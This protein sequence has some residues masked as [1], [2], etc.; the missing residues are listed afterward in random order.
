VLDCNFVRD[1]DGKDVDWSPKRSYEGRVSAE[2]VDWLKADLA[3]TL[4]PTVIISHQGFGP[5]ASGGVVPNGA[6]IR[7]VIAAAN[8]REKGG[9][10]VLCMHGHNH[11]DGATTVEGVHYLQINSA[12]YLWVGEQFGRMAPYVDPLFAFMELDPAGSIRLIGRKSTFRKPTPAERGYP[13]ANA[14]TASIADRVLRFTPP[15]AT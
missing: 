7:A 4:H 9:K 2:Q 13:D 5:K 10:V 3:N 14:V 11:L 1:R 8:H 12:S 6:E 15:R